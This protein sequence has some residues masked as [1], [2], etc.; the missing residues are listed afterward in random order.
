LLCDILQLRRDATNIISTS[1]G[2]FMGALTYEVEAFSDEPV[3]DETAMKEESDASDERLARPRR[4]D[5]SDCSTGLVITAYSMQIR[6]Q[7]R[8]SQRYYMTSIARYIS[9]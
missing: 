5:T 8:A 3:K 6:G 1:K 4:V 9:A 7:Q 2:Q